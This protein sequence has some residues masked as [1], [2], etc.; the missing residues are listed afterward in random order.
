[1]SDVEPLTE[2]CPILG[3]TRPTHPPGG[4][5][6]TIDGHEFRHPRPEISVVVP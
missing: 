4:M 2:W 1:M 6:L 3:C 5:H